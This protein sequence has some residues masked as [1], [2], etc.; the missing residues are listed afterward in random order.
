M[1]HIPGMGPIS[2]ENWLQMCHPESFLQFC[3]N[4][5]VLDV[6]KIGKG[7]T[8]RPPKQPVSTVTLTLT[9]LP[10]DQLLT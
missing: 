9:A 5:S 1:D 10:I 4:T 3:V 8:K 7:G 6:D 2:N